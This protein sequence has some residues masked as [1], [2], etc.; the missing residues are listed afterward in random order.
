MI[1]VENKRDLQTLMR[2]I[3]EIERNLEKPNFQLPITVNYNFTAD[4]QRSFL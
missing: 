1:A 2:I 3:E 4:R